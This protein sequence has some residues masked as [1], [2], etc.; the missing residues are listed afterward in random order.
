[1]MMSLFINI[2]GFHE[3]LLTQIFFK[4]FATVLLCICRVRNVKKKNTE[5]WGQ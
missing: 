4:T 1:M 5:Y 2:L 3:N